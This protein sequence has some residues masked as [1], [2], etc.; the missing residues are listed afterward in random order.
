MNIVLLLY[1]VLRSKK[2]KNFEINALFIKRLT[3][4]MRVN[5]QISTVFTIFMVFI[6]FPVAQVM[7]KTQ[8]LNEDAVL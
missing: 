7:T 3:G 8:R 4:L 6:L 5:T 1:Y 2:Q